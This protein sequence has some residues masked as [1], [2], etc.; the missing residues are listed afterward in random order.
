VGS[1][2]IALLAVKLADELLERVRRNFADAISE[3]QRLRIT[4][5]R[6][7]EGIE[8][9]DGVETLVSH[10]LGRRAVVFVSPVRGAASAGRIDELR[11]G[12]DASKFIKLMA[13]GY[14]ATVTVDL[15][16]M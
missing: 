12:V 13:S 7:L 6:V 5:A 10:T 4:G 16:V 8:L 9:D 1:P 11:D 15:L 2:V 3:I 14:G